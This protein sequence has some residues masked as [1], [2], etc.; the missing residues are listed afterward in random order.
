MINTNHKKLTE[1]LKKKGWSKHYIAKTSHILKKHK[2]SDNLTFWTLIILMILGSGIVFIGITPVLIKA[3]SW[4]FFLIIFVLGL[5]LGFFIDHIIRHLDIDHRHYVFV[6]LFMPLVLT[7]LLFLLLNYVKEIV[8]QL[9]LFISINPLA[10][11]L[12]YMAGYSLPHIIYKI[13]ETK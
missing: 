11:I 13:N 6:G 3:P 10:V 4:L 1:K 9:G 2:K 7:A 8:K 12:I 5:C